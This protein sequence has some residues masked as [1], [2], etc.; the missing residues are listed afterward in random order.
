M[1]RMANSS[2]KTYTGAPLDCSGENTDNMNNNPDLASAW[3]GRITYL[4]YCRE[5]RQANL[6]SQMRLMKKLWKTLSLTWRTVSSKS[7][8]RSGQEYLFL[9]Q[10]STM[11]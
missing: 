8:L 2:G 5:N 4:S 10:R 3:K 9:I 7:L 6:H 1:K 11:S